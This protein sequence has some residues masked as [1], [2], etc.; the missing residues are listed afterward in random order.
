MNYQ[1]KKSLLICI[2]LFL[3]Q[4]EKA[5]YVLCKLKLKK[6]FSVPKQEEEILNFFLLSSN[7]VLYIHAEKEIQYLNPLSLV[8][9][10]ICHKLEIN[11][12]GVFTIHKKHTRT[13][14]GLSL[15]KMQCKVYL[16]TYIY[17]N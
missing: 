17:I 16:R 15:T 7:Q 6:H 13:G 12:S 2:V 5:V 14:P 10:S 1:D 8:L 11:S 4:A 9:P 3:N